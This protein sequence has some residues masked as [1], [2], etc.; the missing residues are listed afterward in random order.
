MAFGRKPAD[1]QAQVDLAKQL[2]RFQNFKSSVIPQKV[3]SDVYQSSSVVAFYSIMRRYLYTGHKD[4]QR[5]LP[6]FFDTIDAQKEECVQLLRPSE[7]EQAR[8]Y[9]QHEFVSKKSSKVKVIKPGEPS[10]KEYDFNSNKIDISPATMQAIKLNSSI[11]Y[12]L[13]QGQNLTT[14]TPKEKRDGYLE[15][16]RDF[17]VAESLVKVKVT[18]E[19]EQ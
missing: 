4:L 11:I 19:I 15:A 8:P 10:K 3:E 16:C 14:F 18:I 9:T 6:I 7:K 12:G 5:A 1:P 2:Y 17:E 13:K